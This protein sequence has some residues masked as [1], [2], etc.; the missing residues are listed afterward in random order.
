MKKP[1]VALTFLLAACGTSA[2]PADDTGSDPTTDTTPD[3]IVD[4]AADVSTDVVVSLPEP[5]R[6]RAIAETCDD[7][8]SSDGPNI[9]PE[10][11]DFADCTSHDDCTE[12]DN[13]RCTDFGRGFWSCSY[14]QC[15]DD[16]GCDDGGCICGEGDFAANQCMR[17]DC[18]VDSDC[19]DSGWCS[20][21][22]GDCGRYSGIIAYYC[23]TVEDECVNDSDC[24]E[25]EFDGYCAFNPAAGYWA[26]SDSECV[27]K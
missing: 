11:A 13:G 26:C 5:D 19:G 3:T 4:T 21:T 18:Q 14:D 12:G 6:H 9:D 24:G 23:H 16:G 10:M 7:T 2:E 8:R 1:I 22:L 25:S 15:F 20:P 17:G 27:G